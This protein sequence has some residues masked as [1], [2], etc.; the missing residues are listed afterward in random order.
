MTV[1]F[2][3][4]Y[5]LACTFGSIFLVTWGSTNWYKKLINFMLTWPLNWDK[6]II[7]SIIWLPVNILFWT[8]LTYLLATSI[9]TLIVRLTLKQS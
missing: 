8:T 6:L 5:S 4:L 7:D 1:I 2:F 9:E 3:I